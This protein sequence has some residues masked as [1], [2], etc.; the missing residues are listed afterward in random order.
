MRNLL[1]VLGL[2]DLPSEAP[3][4]QWMARIRV[5]D[6][7]TCLSEPAVWELAEEVQEQQRMA[8]AV[9]RVHQLLPVLLQITPSEC[10]RGSWP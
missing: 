8:E 4:M 10:P 7:S 5:P 9:G 1:L 3:E 6:A 2:Q